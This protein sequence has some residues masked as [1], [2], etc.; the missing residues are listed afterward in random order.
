MME[1]PELAGTGYVVGFLS[2]LLPVAH[3][4]GRDAPL[5]G[6]KGFGT[7]FIRRISHGGEEIYWRKE[8]VVTAG[9]ASSAWGAASLACCGLR[10]AHWKS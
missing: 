7:F 6:Q 2:M 5:L 4:L 3:D 10:S 9:D 8:R 1:L